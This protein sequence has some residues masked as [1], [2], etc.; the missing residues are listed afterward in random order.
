MNYP[1]AL[2][3][4]ARRLYDTEPRNRHLAADTLRGYAKEPGYQR[5][6]AG[7]REQLRVPVIESRIAAV[8]LLG[9]LRDPASVPELIPL[10]VAPEAELAQAVVSALTVI[11]G[12][13]FGY[14]VPGWSQWWRGNY[15]RPRPAWLLQGLRHPSVDMRRLANY[16]LQLLTGMTTHYDP[17]AHDAEREEKVRMWESWWAHVS[18]GRASGDSAAATG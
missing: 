11:C 17:D 1:G 7:L 9:Q 5:I 10:A 13:E 16:E 15:N 8:Q 6:V 2:E 4:L 12:Q 18:G 14:D 3:P